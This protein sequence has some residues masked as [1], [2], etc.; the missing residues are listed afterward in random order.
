VKTSVKALTVL[1]LGLYLYSRIFSGTLLFYINQRF[2]W[3]VML[4][5][6]LLMA[7]GA[8][9]RYRSNHDHAYHTHAFSW[10]GVLLIGLV[11]AL[12]LLVPPKPL[13]AAAMGN[14]EVNMGTLVSTQGNSAMP[15]RAGEKNI[16]DWL[17]AFQ[18]TP[19]PAAFAHQPAHLIGFVYR[20]DRFNS[21]NFM[22]SRFV[23]S[24]CVADATAVGLIV[25]SPQAASLPGD[26]WV[27][28]SG[29]FEPGEFSS[30]PTPI[31]ITDAITRTT[32]PNQPYLY[33]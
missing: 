5:G 25:R 31:L 3:L 19:D 23:V 14:R 17:I 18:N 15:T 33:P 22:L 26:Q 2:A 4:A 28:V 1:G 9:Y 13:G 27:E 12:G 20:D 21:E 7:I 8:S 6:I 29:H 10:G 16:L 32:P 30:K 24:C 11:I